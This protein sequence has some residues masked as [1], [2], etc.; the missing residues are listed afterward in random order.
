MHVIFTPLRRNEFSGIHRGG[1]GAGAGAVTHGFIQSLHWLRVS[2]LV[3]VATPTCA[4]H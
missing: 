1:A 4:L 3:L 2:G